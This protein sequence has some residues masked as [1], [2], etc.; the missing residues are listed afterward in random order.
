MDLK[1]AFFGGIIPVT[2]DEPAHGTITFHDKPEPLSAIVIPRID[3]NGDLAFDFYDAVGDVS[4]FLPRGD[5][6]LRFHNGRSIEGFVASMNTNLGSEKMQCSGRLIATQRE[7]EV[8]DSKI[9][10]ANCAIGDFPLFHG[11]FA[12]H[13]TKTATADNTYQESARILGHA[14]FL[15]D[16]WQFKILENLDKGEFTHWGSIGR[17]DNSVF[18]FE[19]LR[20]VIAALTYFFTFITGVYR[21]PGIV[22]GYD[23]QNRPVWGRIASFK[24]NKY[25]SDN[26]FNPQS[27]TAIAQLFPGFWR[28][29]EDHPQETSGV[30][31]NYAES[32]IICHAG[33][34]K[35]ALNNSQTALEGLARWV[36]GRQ[37]SPREQAKEYI[38]EA[39]NK[40]GV[41]H[42][43]LGYSKVL[44]LWQEKYKEDQDDDDGLTFI[45]RLRNKSTHS[46]FTEMNPSDYLYAWNLSQ[47]YVELMLLWLFDYN[48]DHQSRIESYR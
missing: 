16:G 6:T 14:E 41:S 39:L 33:L 21:T 4:T 24:Q 38:K 5:A 3:T 22:I 25:H 15:V 32:S 36:L 34:P 35:N 20:H 2:L 46:E 13:T 27:R 7:V 19:Q 43:L 30:V 47:Y 37:K 26:W 45:T 18:S 23:S 9:A 11:A 28:C 31:G 1:K 42:D 8:M 40:A 12:T 48:Q 44:R 29:F 10:V 17:V